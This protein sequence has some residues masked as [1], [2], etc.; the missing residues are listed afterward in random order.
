MSF[1]FF[2]VSKVRD[3]LPARA[4][5]LAD[6]W[7]DLP[8][9]YMQG[10]ENLNKASFIDAKVNKWEVNH[11]W[12]DVYGIEPTVR[13]ELLKGDALKAYVDDEQ[14]VPKVDLE[15]DR[16]VVLE[17][18]EGGSEIDDVLALALLSVF[19]RGGEC[20]RLEEGLHELREAFLSSLPSKDAIRSAIEA[21][22]EA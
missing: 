13:V 6:A 21:G 4:A 14:W 20:Y 11:R 2:V 16:L 19:A 12:G 8:V 10:H 1:K 9:S 18:D 7:G 22:P 15:T 5:L 17:R 3:P